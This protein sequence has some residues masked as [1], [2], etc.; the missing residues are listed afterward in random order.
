[1]SELHPNDK[2][3]ALQRALRLA[4]QAGETA[5]VV[6]DL[7]ALLAEAQQEARK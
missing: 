5:N 2:V 4:E 3:Y 1:M 7:R 6:N